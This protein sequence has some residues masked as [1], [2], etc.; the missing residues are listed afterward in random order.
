MTITPHTQTHVF[1]T[2]LKSSNGAGNSVGVSGATSACAIVTAVG[3]MTAQEFHQ[4]NK[5]DKA[6]YETLKKDEGFCYW[7]WICQ[8][9][10]N[11]PNT[12]CFR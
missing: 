9:C 1:S 2:P 11:A 10:P 7:K 5:K 4:G 12:P 8:N 6:H 3:P